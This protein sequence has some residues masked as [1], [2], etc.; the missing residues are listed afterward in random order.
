[1]KIEFLEEKGVVIGGGLRINVEFLEG[2]GKVIVNGVEYVR[3]IE[4]QR[5]IN[6]NGFDVPEPIREEPEPGQ[7]IYVADITSYQFIL[8]HRWT[9]DGYDKRYL[10]R[11]LAHLSKENAIKHAKALLSFTNTGKE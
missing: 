11:G 10:S 4:I 9:G 7:R 5:T 8:E 1:M 6:I 2:K 3:L